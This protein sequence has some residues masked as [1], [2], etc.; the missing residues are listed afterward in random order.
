LRERYPWP[1]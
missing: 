1:V